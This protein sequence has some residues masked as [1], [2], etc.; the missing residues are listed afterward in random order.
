VRR[1]LWLFIFALGLAF[2]TWPLLSIFRN[3][4]VPALFIIWL[5]FIALI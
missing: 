3:S 1:D 4:L 2:F 5:A